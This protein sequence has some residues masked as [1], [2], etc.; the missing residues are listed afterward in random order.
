MIFLI[1]KR[2]IFPMK[3]NI[4]LVQSLLIL[5]LMTPSILLSMGTTIEYKEKDKEIKSRRQMKREKKHKAEQEK[6]LRTST[7]IAQ[8]PKVTVETEALIQT[9]EIVPMNISQD[10]EIDQAILQSIITEQQTL[11][12][13]EITKELSTLVGKLEKLAGKKDVLKILGAL[14]A[15]TKTDEAPASTKVETVHPTT[16]ANET[17]EPVITDDAREMFAQSVILPT[18]KKDIGYLETAKIRVATVTGRLRYA[19]IAALENGSFDTENA[20]SFELL[21]NAFAEATVK[22]DFEA[23]NKLATLSE[24]G[25]YKGLIRISDEVARAAF[26]SCCTHHKNWINSATLITEKINDQNAAKFNMQTDLFKAQ[27]KAASELY[28]QQ[29]QKIIL[30]GNQSI[31]PQQK[32][33]EQQRTALAS[34]GYLNKTIRK[35]INTFLTQNTPNIPKNIVAAA[36][37]PSDRRLQSILNRSN[38]PTIEKQLCETLEAECEKLATEKAL[39]IQ[40]Q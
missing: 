35:D 15:A 37:E 32:Q 4:L 9:A 19:V 33:L 40:N 30:D 23:L 11:V 17:I 8:E 25:K 21:N 22:N 38:V 3:K 2:R 31:E 26:E 28:Q 10:P 36:Q 20:L 14:Q 12:T 13:E 6:L 29:V 7:E 34:L 27:I 1:Q 5:P 39:L 16:P 18:E 24:T